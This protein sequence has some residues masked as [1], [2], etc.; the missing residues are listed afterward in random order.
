[1]GRR[2][3]KRNKHRVNERIRA[4]KVRLIDPD[5][6]QVGVVDLEEALDHADEADLV[7]VAP[8]AKP[9]VCRVMD[10]GKWRYKQQ[11]RRQTSKA[12]TSKVKEIRMRPTTDEH[13]VQVKAGHARRFLEKG[14]KVLCSMLFRGREMAHKELGENLMQQFAEQLGDASEI[15]QQPKMDGRKMTMMLSPN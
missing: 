9:P 6:N 5:G 1:M 12:N 10:Y 4:R 14:D 2:G 8:Q 13:D 3:S 7:E 11:K 15:E